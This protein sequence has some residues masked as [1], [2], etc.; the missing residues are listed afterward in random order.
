MKAFFYI[1][2]SSVVISIRTCVL[3]WREGRLDPLEWSFGRPLECLFC[4]RFRQTPCSQSEGRSKFLG[5]SQVSFDTY[6][7]SIFSELTQNWQPKLENV[8]IIL[9]RVDVVYRVGSAWDDDCLEAL[10]FDVLGWCGKRQ[11]LWFD[12]KLSYFAIDYLKINIK[13]YCRRLPRELKDCLPLRIG[14][15]HLE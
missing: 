11:N 1:L 9:W 12:L 2:R 13:H 4:V 14:H 5:G 3:T 15:L 10:L 7:R 6:F 8:G